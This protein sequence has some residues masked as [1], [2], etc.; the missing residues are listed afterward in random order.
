MVALKALID[1]RVD[2][3]RAYH[4]PAR[5]PVWRLGQQE[6]PDGLLI[7]ACDAT[8]LLQSASADI[9]A[10]DVALD[11]ATVDGST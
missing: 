3:L 9:E 8:R 2:D 11:A 5:C 6:W 7:S 10:H 1:T 4:L